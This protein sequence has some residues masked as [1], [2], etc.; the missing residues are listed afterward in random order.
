M[1]E[2][3][4][5]ARRDQPVIRLSRIEKRFGNL[6]VLRGVDLEVFRGEAVAIL[7]E[8]GSGKSVLLKVLIGLLRADR[9]EVRLF[10]TDAGRLSEAEWEPLR[11]RSGMLFQGGALFDSLSVAENVAFPLRERHYP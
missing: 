7:G 1:A 3:M 5:D 2:R 11:R 4:T 10:D 6:A 8:S 9:G